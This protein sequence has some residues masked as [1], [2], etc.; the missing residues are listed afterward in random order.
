MP[1]INLNTIRNLFDRERITKM[2]TARRYYAN[3]NDIMQRKRMIAGPNGEPI[4]ARLLSNNK[5]SHAFI[6]KIVRQ[7]VT[8]LLGKPFNIDGDDDALVERMNEI[9]D[10]DFRRMLRRVAK[11]AILCG[12][13]WIAVYYD[14]SGNLS[15]TRIKPE[16]VGV[17]YADD[18]E[19]EIET[20]VRRYKKDDENDQTQAANPMAIDETGQ[21]YYEVWTQNDVTTYREVNGKLQKVSERPQFFVDGQNGGFEHIPFV[22]FRYNDEGQSILDVNKTLIDDYD[23]TVSDLS[24]LLCDTPNSMRVIKGYGTPI[25]EIVRNLATFNAVNIAPDADIQTIQN[26]IDIQAHE[27]HL[28]RMRKD[29]YDVSCAVD[30]QEASQGNLSGVAIK[31]RYADLDLDCQEMGANFAASLTEL[32]A[33]VCED[34]RTKG[35]GEHD[36]AS[37]QFIW[38]TELMANES[39]VIQNLM[40]AADIMSL[41]TRVAMNPYVDDPQAELER[42]EGEQNAAETRIPGEWKAQTAQSPNTLS[43][44]GEGEQD[45]AKTPENNQ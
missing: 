15:F 5:L 17:V 3:E 38:A 7:K 28:N 20:I 19:D 13:G 14:E 31:F 33:F 18:N 25:E 24:N 42:M 26:S 21:W 8:Y 44:D 9:C 22:R 36:P 29:I 4:E 12:D 11:D 43:V 23:R 34:M 6:K 41:E 1:D 27:A 10:A 39:E 35:E 37:L 30:T 16:C 45:E 32:A 2:L 40:N